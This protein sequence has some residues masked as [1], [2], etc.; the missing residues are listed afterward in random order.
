MVPMADGFV[1]FKDPTTGVVARYPEHYGDLF[2]HLERVT[3][4]E[5][6]C[7]P[8]LLTPLDEVDDVDDDDFKPEWL[9]ADQDEEGD[10]GR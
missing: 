8:C 4:S 2:P 7:V 5:V 9:G 1:A 6:I 3:E 10:N